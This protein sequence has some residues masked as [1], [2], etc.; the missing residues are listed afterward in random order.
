MDTSSSFLDQPHRTSELHDLIVEARR[1]LALEPESKHPE[2]RELLSRAADLEEG[3]DR[4]RLLVESDRIDEAKALL[5]SI[6]ADDLS[7]DL[8]PPTEL[9]EFVGDLLDAAIRAGG[10]NT[11]KTIPAP[12]PPSWEAVY[13]RCTPA[14]CADLDMV[15]HLAKTAGLNAA[16]W[17]L[18]AG[19]PITNSL[20]ALVLQA[21]LN[22]PETVK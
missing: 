1:I 2:A 8:A 17:R 14:F 10:E 9:H 12:P 22:D 7:A 6:E 5:D 3:T 15:R 4:L 11:R 16:T 21:L 13:E 20:T 18:A 19:S